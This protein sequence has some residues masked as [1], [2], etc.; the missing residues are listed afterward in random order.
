MD[1]GIRANVRPRRSELAGWDNLASV[2]SPQR[3]PDVYANSL[4]DE[5]GMAIREQHVRA[6]W[7]EASGSAS[8]RDSR[9]WSIVA[10]W[11]V[12]GKE[13]IIESLIPHSVVPVPPFNGR[14]IWNHSSQ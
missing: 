11:L 12:N 2:A 10:T 3:T 9:A 5:A 7:V 13:V 8:A 6:T 1:Q 4:M 14:D